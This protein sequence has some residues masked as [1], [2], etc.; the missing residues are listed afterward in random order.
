MFESAFI[1]TDKFLGRAPVLGG[2][3][4]AG[5]GAAAAHFM[6]KSLPVGAAIGAVAG[7]AGTEAGRALF[8]DKKVLLELQVK[9]LKDQ[10]KELIS[11][12]EEMEAAKAKK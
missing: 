3:A 12:L 9:N 8:T 10:E 2:L 1:A 5:A 4:G 11:K 6:E 7:V